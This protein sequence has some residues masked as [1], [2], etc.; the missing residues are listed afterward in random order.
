MKQ[1]SVDDDSSWRA[2]VRDPRGRFR[3]WREPRPLFGGVCLLLGA[4][5]IGYVPIHFAAD[6]MLIGGAFSIL[7]VLLAIL[8]GFCG[9]AAIAKP[10]LSSIFGVLGATFGTLSLF[11]ALGG[12]FVGTLV[13]TIGG[14]LCYAWTPPADYAYDETTLTD[15]SEFIWQETGGFVWQRS[16]GFVWQTDGEDAE[17]GDDLDET[18]EFDEKFEL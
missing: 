1:Q 15:A 7:G 13:S 6:L 14:I 8:V 3:N 12:L 18:D 2:W 5:I 10:E 16:G 17:D 4:L 9:V 11:G